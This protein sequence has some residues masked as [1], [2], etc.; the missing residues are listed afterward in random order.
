MPR[1]RVRAASNA[2]V[3]GAKEPRPAC[4]EA[5]PLATC[6]VMWR[7]IYAGS[8]LIR[9]TERTRKISKHKFKLKCIHVEI[10]DAGPG[11]HHH[12]PR[13]TSRS[14]REY[15]LRR[16]GPQS[17]FATA[18]RIRDAARHVVG[19]GGDRGGGDRRGLLHAVPTM[20]WHQE[21]DQDGGP[22]RAFGGLDSLVPEVS[23]REAHHFPVSQPRRFAISPP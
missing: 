17:A 9:K 22:D 5:E 16:L 10:G 4:P 3:R 23:E 20:G 19:S 21:V 8:F 11:G 7:A 6:I 1:F 15:Y 14:T 18:I 13:S 12:P 2:A